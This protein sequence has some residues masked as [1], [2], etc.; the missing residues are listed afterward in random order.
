MALL[1]LKFRRVDS[2]FSLGGCKLLFRSWIPGER[3]A[4]FKTFEIEDD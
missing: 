4:D 1:D 3:V 2:K